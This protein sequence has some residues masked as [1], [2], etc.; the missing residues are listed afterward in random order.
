MSNIAKWA[1]LIAGAIALIALV[2]T[3][4]FASFLNTGDVADTVNQIVGICGNAFSSARG[5]INNFLLP[6]G[7]TILSGIIVYLF[8]KWVIISGIKITTWI[9]HFI[10]K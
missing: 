7:R 10:F 8:A 4:P 6:Q 3:L 2:M 5:L 1:L 9:Y